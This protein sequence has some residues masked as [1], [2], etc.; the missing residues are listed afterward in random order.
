[1]ILLSSYLKVLLVRAALQCTSALG[2]LSISTALSALELPPLWD[3]EE[4]LQGAGN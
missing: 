2:A 1:M 3:W 4:L